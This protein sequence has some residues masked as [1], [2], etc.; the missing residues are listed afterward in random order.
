MNWLIEKRYLSSTSTY[1]CSICLNYAKEKGSI[2]TKA[3]NKPEKPAASKEVV[4][5]NDSV[6]KVAELI[7]NGK[8]TNDE[9]NLLCKTIGESIG[10][11]IS[12]RI[13]NDSPETQYKNLNDTMNKDCSTHLKTFDQNLLEILTGIPNT[14][15]KHNANNHNKQKIYA[16]CLAAEQIYFLRNLN[17]IGGLNFSLL[18]DSMKTYFCFRQTLL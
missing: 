15:I 10:K 6:L 16:C 11:N 3:G 17:Y 14:N 12:A 18:K 5:K 4:D 9:M 7:K 8:I 13:Q 2:T 1:F